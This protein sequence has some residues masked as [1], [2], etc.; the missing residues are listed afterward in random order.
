MFAAL[1]FPLPRVCDKSFHDF[2]VHKGFAAEKVDFQVVTR[3]RG[4]YQKVEGGFAYLDGH[5]RT[6]AEILDLTCE[7]EFAVEIAGVRHVQAQCFDY[8][9]A[10]C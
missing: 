8:V 1:F 10:F 4:L 6:V 3:P 5:Q 9:G 7:D 2:P